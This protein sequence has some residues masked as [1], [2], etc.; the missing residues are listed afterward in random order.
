M[1]LSK[2]T[3]L[4]TTTL[5]LLGLAAASQ[6]DLTIFPEES[7]T[8]VNSFTSYE[9]EVENI[10]P[11]KDV[12]EIQHNYP[13]EISV[14]PNQ[15]ELESGQSE[16]I[17]VWF[18]PRVDR[19]A[20]TYSFQVSADSRA[21]G[22]TYSTSGRVNVI[23]D[24]E[25][26]V[27]GSDSAVVCRGETARYEIDVTNDGIQ[28]EEF[29]VTTE[30]GELDRNRVNLDQGET[31]T[32]V[33]TASSSEVTEESFNV[34]A[35]STTSYATE[36]MNVQF[37]TENC[38]D[39][40]ISISPGTQ[41]TA[42]FTESEFDVTVRNLGTRSDEFT[43]STDRGELSETTVEVDADSTETATLRF[44]PE[45]LGEQQ[46]TVQASGNSETTQT[47]TV[48]SYNGMSSNVEFDESRTV[49]RDESATYT[50]TV[51]N[52][53]EAAETFNLSSNTGEVLEQQVTVD[54]GES[55]ETG[56]TVNASGME[57]G[58]HEVTFSSQASTFEGPESSAS[59]TFTVE[60]CWDVGMNIVPEIA[61]AGE[62]MST[63]YEVK[64]SNPGTKENS[65]RLT[66]Q[67]PEWVEI[68]PETVTVAPGATESVYMY[69]GVP[70]EKRGEVEI[71]AVAEG[72]EVRTSET[73]QLVINDDVEEA[74]RSNRGDLV[75]RFSSS[76]SGLYTA[77]TDSSNVT[78]GVAAI[79][80]GLVITAVILVREW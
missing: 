5:M 8:E 30:Y 17:N 65:Y 46:L 16:T 19:D 66:H 32:V 50:V 53:G 37:V 29:A 78:R 25:V 52:D 71:T 28:Q 1:K 75:G 38:F 7:S 67:G 77:I 54:A 42:A 64:V 13:G 11:V 59:T 24:H 43:L 58:E 31:T 22:Q 69:A 15:V 62:N 55:V 21:D 27:S 72:N 3:V 12:Y 48:N 6:A 47:V 9:V 2:L 76:A 61:S 4:L 41:E 68:R 35:S 33:L 57:D 80:A 44:T 60:N 39:S 51:E 18:N 49:C 34:R 14:A 74:I 79:I 20:G 73:V 36:S 40:E 45:E 23:R 26:S 56:L 70:F 63:I 10:G